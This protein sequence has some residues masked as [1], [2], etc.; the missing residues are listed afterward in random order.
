MLLRLQRAFLEAILG[1]T[2]E[3]WGARAVINPRGGGLSLVARRHESEDVVGLI[4][5][6][7]GEVT[8][9]VVDDEEIVRLVAESML[10]HAG[11]EVRTAS[12]ASEAL[13]LLSNNENKFDA[14]LLDLNMPDVDGREALT[15]IHHLRPGLPVIIASGYDE[16]EIADAVG[17]AAVSGFVRKPFGFATLVEALRVALKAETS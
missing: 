4:G 8:V 2:E 7:A 15:Q 10:R 17:G 11:M 16:R 13:E 14:V 1:L 12:D 5:E 6:L 3:P 9:L